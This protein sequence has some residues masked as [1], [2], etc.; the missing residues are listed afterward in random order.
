MTTGDAFIFGAVFVILDVLDGALAR[1]S[2]AGPTRIGAAL[3]VES[4]SMAMLFLSLAAGRK[5]F[6]MVWFG[7]WWWMGWGAGEIALEC[8]LP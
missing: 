3:D 6:R 5:V 4:D 8:I 1:G 7:F 2:K